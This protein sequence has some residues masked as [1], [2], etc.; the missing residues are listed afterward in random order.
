MRF[1]SQDKSCRHG[2]Q[3]SRQPKRLCGKKRSIAGAGCE[4]DFNQSIV[5]SPTKQERSESNLCTSKNAARVC[6]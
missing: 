1:A 6:L 2:G 3:Y 4:L 5:R